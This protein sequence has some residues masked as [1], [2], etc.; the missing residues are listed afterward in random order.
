MNN[1]KQLL[2]DVSGLVIKDHATGIQRVVRSYLKEL[3]DNPP[4]GYKIEPVY[5]K[6]SN[7]YYTKNGKRY[8][9]Y[10]EETKKYYYAKKFTQTFLG[11]PK[12]NSRDYEIS[13]E[14]GDVFFVLDFHHEIQL[15]HKSF[16]EALYSKGVIVK[17]LVHDLLP[18]ELSKEYFYDDTLKTKHE[19]LMKLIASTDGAI[20]VSNATAIA[21]EEWL[22]KESVPQ[23]PTFTIDWVHNG[24]DIDASVPSRGMPKDA[25]NVLKKLESKTTFIT[26]G[27]IEPRK[28][29]KQ[30]LAAF[31]KLWLESKDVNLVIVGKI[32][33][34]MQSLIDDLLIHPEYGTRLFY[35]NGISD[36]YLSKIYDQSQ[37]LIAA[38]INE[39]FGLPI[40]EAAHHKTPLIIRDIDV[41]RELAQEFAM[42]FS[43]HTDNDLSTVID[44]WLKLYASNE[45]PKSDNITWSTWKQSTEKL[46]KLLV[47]RD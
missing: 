38:S 36:E 6:T 10:I 33:W 27:T 37:C 32:G 28:G 11:K 2:L 12:T 31:T 23:S 40:V 44:K 22:K 26:V 15:S 4:E 42:Y 30:I 25:K 34:K 18:I 9:F 8:A 3:L 16:Y 21:Y 46:K 14:K 47:N 45:H 1:K 20:C 17:F 39:G 7:N 5:A 24:G 19:N 29:H 43:G 13:A 35:F 41:F